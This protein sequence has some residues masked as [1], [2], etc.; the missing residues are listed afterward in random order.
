LSVQ[1]TKGD[2]L[3][4]K[5][6]EFCICNLTYIQNYKKTTIKAIKQFSSYLETIHQHNDP[7]KEPSSP[8]GSKIQ[9][10]M[11]SH[12]RKLEQHANKNIANFS[13]NYNIK[14]EINFLAETD[15]I[16]IEPD[17][18]W[19]FESTCVK[20]EP[21]DFVV[22][23]CNATKSEPEEQIEVAA[24]SI[25]EPKKKKPLAKKIKID[26]ELKRER[27]RL[28]TKKKKKTRGESKPAKEEN[29]SVC[30]LCGKAYSAS[31]MKFHMNS[32]NGKYHELA[33]KV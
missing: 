25:F 9:Y 17:S 15:S 13:Q 24:L 16:K 26:P 1:I 5:I 33:N 30:E 28:K 14:G 22:T 7:H 11:T 3:P 8:A 4:D 31:A 10:S 21:N 19:N 27:P 12:F 32:H 2:N 20:V 6:C 18:D 23:E 29:K